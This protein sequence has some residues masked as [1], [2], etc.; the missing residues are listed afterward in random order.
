[1]V[2]VL[3]ERFWQSKSI[4]DRHHNP[5]FTGGTVAQ[6]CRNQAHNNSPHLPDNLKDLLPRGEET[7]MICARSAA[8]HRNFDGYSKDQLPGQALHSG[9]KWWDQGTFTLD[10]RRN[11]FMERMDK[12]WN[13]LPR[14]GVKSPSLELCTKQLLPAL[15]GWQGGDWSQ[16]GLNYFRGT[17]QP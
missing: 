13:R 6:R 14:T 4:T 11:F 12:G 9:N 5:R 17:F 10:I 1:M 8:Q 16:V 15:S 7:G 2:V 3:L